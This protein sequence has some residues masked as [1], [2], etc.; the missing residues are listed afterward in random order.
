MLKCSVKIDDKLQK[1]LNQKM[2]NRFMIAFIVSLVGLVAYVAVSMFVEYKW[3]DVLLWVF[4]IIFGYS[5]V[6][7]ITINK[8]NKKTAGNNLSSQLEINEDFMIIISFKNNIQFA[9]T[10]IF[11]KEIIKVKETENY[12]FLYPDKS[13]AFPIPKSEFTSEE[14]SLIKVWVYSAKNPAVKTK[15]G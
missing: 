15:L 12:L 5:L 13:Q 7:I 4:A 3:L 1:E 9:T 8:I 14:F 2:K 6:M 10:K 11:Y